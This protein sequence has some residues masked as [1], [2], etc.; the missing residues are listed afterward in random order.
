MLLADENLVAKLLLGGGGG[1]GK[2]GLK[3]LIVREAGVKTTG[4]LDALA[5]RLKDA[6]EGGE[7]V[8]GWRC[9]EIDL[10]DNALD[11]VSRVS[12]RP[13]QLSILKSLIDDLL[14]ELQLEPV[15]GYL[16]LRSF[17][18]ERNCFRQPAARV[19]EKGGTAALLVWLRE[20]ASLDP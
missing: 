4:G 2:G 13:K 7:V 9:E 19:W 17:V 16:L 1:E 11:K 8:K 10:T 18:V 6:E 14:F 3:K 12:S 5:R 15:L 20:R